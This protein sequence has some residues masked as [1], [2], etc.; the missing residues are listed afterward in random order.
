MTRHPDTSSA[1]TLD[2]LRREIDRV[3]DALHDLLMQRAILSAKVRK[4]KQTD[5]H[6]LVLAY[7]PAR[8]AAMLRRL[9]A[10][11]HGDLPFAAIARIWREIIASSTQLQSPYGL[12]ICGGANML[13]VHDI[14]RFYY[15]AMARIHVHDNPRAVIDAVAADPSGLGLLPAP[16]PRSDPWWPHMQ[17]RWKRDF[18]IIAGLPFFRKTA[19]PPATPTILVIAHAPFE[20]SGDDTT[21]VVLGTDQ[22]LSAGDID[23]RI[24]ASGLAGHILQETT[25]QG[26][27]G[28]RRILLALAGC[29][30]ADDPALG[31]MIRTGETMTILGGYANPIIEGDAT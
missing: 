15:G 23:R 7:R 21:L 14:G 8:E 11:H 2:S 25:G 5:R 16:E 17:D 13:A 12:Y 18:G 19:S 6:E 4:T 28:A 20:P 1:D 29:L 22:S 24:G 27:T 10:R 26:K 31:A 3:D 9:R 30:H